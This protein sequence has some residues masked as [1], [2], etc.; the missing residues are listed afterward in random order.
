MAQRPRHRRRAARGTH[1]NPATLTSPDGLLPSLR[2]WPDPDIEITFRTWS[3]DEIVADVSLFEVQRQERL[4]AFCGFLRLL[5]RT[6]DTPVALYPE[7][8]SGHQPILA[9]HVDPPLSQFWVAGP[10]WV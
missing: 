7:G 6:L 10:W 4:D 9:Y 8:D 5:G 2:I 1:V 3:P